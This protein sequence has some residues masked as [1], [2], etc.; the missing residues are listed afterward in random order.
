ML[1]YL[2]NAADKPVAKV[3]MFVL[4]FSFVGWG[5]AEWIFGGVSRDTTLIHVGNADVSVQQFNNERSRQLSSM[6]KEE[7]HSAYTDPVKAAE[8]TNN[9]MANLTVN[10]LALNRAK[11]LGFVVSDKRIADEIKSNAQ[12]QINGQFVPW[13][14]DMVVQNSGVSEQDIVDSLRGDIMRQMAVGASRVPLAVS[15]FAVDALYNARYTKRDIDYLTVKFSDFK[16]KDPSDEDLRGYYAQ[17]PKIVPESRSV[18]YVFLSADMNKPD[19]YD[20]GFKKAQLIEDMIISGDSLK[21]AADKHDAK[22]VQITDVKRGEKSSD[23]ILSDDLV[24]KV[25]SMDSGVES[26][27]LELKDGFVI[28]RVDSIVA[29][30]NADF[31]DVKKSLVDDWKKSEQRKRA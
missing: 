22:F 17:N 23:K 18:S 13:M 15:E 11:D 26:E 3:L 16:V 25:F 5:A 28:L 12:F 10:Q 31:D 21:E 1:E 14:F 29:Q 9:V 30:H 20:V 19:E 2:R 7:Q 8:L 27:L 6:S 24:A 4:I